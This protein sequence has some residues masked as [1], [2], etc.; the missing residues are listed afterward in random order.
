[1]DE[2][3]EE[4]LKAAFEKAVA[5][6]HTQFESPRGWMEKVHGENERNAA[7]WIDWSK[8]P[9]A[10]TYALGELEAK[11]RDVVGELIL[12][13]ELQLSVGVTAVTVISVPFD[14]EDISKPERLLTIPKAHLEREPDA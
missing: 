7:Q 11:R 9:A 2:E 13:R 4:Q 5:W 6:W 3:R 8:F 1:M 12:A 14:W 10:A